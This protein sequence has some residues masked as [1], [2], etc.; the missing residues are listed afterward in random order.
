MPFKKNWYH[1]NY[2]SEKFSSE[3]MESLKK[4]QIAENGKKLDLPPVNTL[5]PKSFDILAE[6][7]KMS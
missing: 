3:L 1:F 4:P 5:L 7:S 6:D 2:S